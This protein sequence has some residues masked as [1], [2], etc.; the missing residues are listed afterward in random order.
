[1]PLAFVVEGE[2]VSV[3]A[4]IQ[5]FDGIT[6]CAVD[7]GRVVLE[8]NGV[9]RSYSVDGDADDL[10]WH[11]D[12]PLGST[13]VH[14][15]DR[16][17]QPGAALTHGSLIAPM[18]GTVT[19]VRVA[20]GDRVVGGQAIVTIEAMKMEHSL[21]TPY[22]GT[23]SEVRVNPGAQVANGEVLVVVDEDEDED[24]QPAGSA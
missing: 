2:D 8:Q 24:E 22:P 15:V 13:E 5:E 18:P 17:P 23:V 19:S 9:R 7:E 1:M 6:V 4:R 10:T 21:R 14:A 20:V 11:V 16:F 12:S 3:P